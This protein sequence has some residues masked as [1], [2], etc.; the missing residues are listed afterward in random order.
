SGG[1]A[2]FM[3]TGSVFMSLII[4]N[5]QHHLK[6]QSIRNLPKNLNDIM[7]S[8]LRAEGLSL[9][10]AASDVLTKRGYE[11][12]GLG[13]EINNNVAVWECWLGVNSAVAL[14]QSLSNYPPLSDDAFNRNSEAISKIVDDET[15]PEWG[16]SF[17]E[18]IPIKFKSEEV[19]AAEFQWRWLDRE[20]ING[21][22][23]RVTVPR[24]PEL[25]GF[26]LSRLIEDYIGF[27]QAACII[28]DAGIIQEVRIFGDFLADTD[29]IRLLE[30][31]LRW[32][33]L[34]KRPIALIIDDILGSQG[35][36]ILGLKRLGSILE[37]IMDAAS[38]ETT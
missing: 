29:G 5:Y 17:V 7:L 25:K 8:A 13:F 31:K 9:S 37:A 24:E 30:E 16:F 35:H 10:L 3:D 2:I 14:P 21:L 28:N 23:D 18:M 4:P 15:L 33:P 19:T 32:S 36:V 26:T 22:L 27:V 34:K 20:R 38:R 6:P 1:P 11:I 12:G